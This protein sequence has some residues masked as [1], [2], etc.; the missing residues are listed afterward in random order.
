MSLTVPQ[1]EKLFMRQGFT[2]RGIYI[3]GGFLALLDQAG[4]EPYEWGGAWTVTDAAWLPI[5]REPQFRAS[6]RP[7][8]MPHCTP[9]GYDRCHRGGFGP[10][11]RHALIRNFLTYNRTEQEWRPQFALSP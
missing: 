2:T 7:P 6:S 9:K 5:R 10:R 8:G 4:G 11:T 3:K 1:R